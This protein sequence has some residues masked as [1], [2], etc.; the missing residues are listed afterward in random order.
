[1]V[2]GNICIRKRPKKIFIKKVETF[3]QFIAIF[4]QLV[5]LINGEE[6]LVE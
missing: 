6:K 3:L 4:Q 2:N 1:M 5:E